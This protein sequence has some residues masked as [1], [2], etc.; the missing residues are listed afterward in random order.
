MSVNGK[1]Y[2]ITNS[3]NNLTYIGSTVQTLVNRFKQHNRDMSKHISLKLYK[4]MRQFKAE[5]FYIQLI[6]QSD[7]TDIRELRQREGM[8]IKMLNP[9]LN[10]NIPGRTIAQYNIDNKDRLKIYRREYYREYRKRNYDFLKSYRHEYYKNKK[11]A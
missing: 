7:Y 11:Q 4:A 5:N 10:K 3:V 2:S 6:E 1:I 9:F 8:Y